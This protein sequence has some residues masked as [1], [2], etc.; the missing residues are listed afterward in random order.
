ML[1]GGYGCVIGGYGSLCYLRGYG[2]LFGG[3]GCVICGVWL[4]FRGY[5]LYLGGMV[6]LSL[7]ASL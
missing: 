7:V 3:Y 5:G 2:L 4:L 6:V 1:F